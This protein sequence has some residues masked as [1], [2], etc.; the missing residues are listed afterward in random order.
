MVQTVIIGTLLVALLE[1]DTTARFIVFATAL[2]IAFGVSMLI[3]FLPKVFAVLFPVRKE[4]VKITLEGTK[5]VPTVLRERERPEN[6]AASPLFRLLSRSLFP[7]RAVQDIIL[8]K[9]APEEAR[10]EHLPK[11]EESQGGRFAME[12]TSLPMLFK[13]AREES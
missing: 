4:Q 10:H 9:V 1:D 12:T 2:I 13:Q 11:I 8:D 6:Y 5:L 3:V 7:S